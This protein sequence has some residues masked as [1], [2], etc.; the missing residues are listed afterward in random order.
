MNQSHSHWTIV[1]K[2]CYILIVKVTKF[3]HSCLLV[4]DSGKTFLFDPGNYTDQANVLNLDSIKLDY[5]LITHEHPDHM[6]I[7]LVRKISG[8]FPEVSIITNP[9]AQLV[10]KNEGI[11]VS[12]KVPDF[13]TIEKIPHGKI[14]G[15]EV[16]ENIKFILNN[17]LTHPGDS[18]SFNQTSK[19]LALPVQAPWG[20]LTEAV[21]LATKLKP[22]IILPIHDWHWR[23]EARVM[24]YRRLTDYFNNLGIR[25]ISLETGI[26][27]DL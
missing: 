6:Y 11:E 19:I 26:P 27:I 17:I 12:G 15:S 2:Y 3:V 20:S 4:E 22:E 10:L 14:F 25:F 18:F 5:L 13:I 8:K 24:L 21:E 9:S 7:P 23:D 16:P 1:A